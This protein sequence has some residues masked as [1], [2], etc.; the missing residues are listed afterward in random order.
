M[1]YGRPVEFGFFPIP[2]ADD[3]AEVV[4]QVRLGDELGLDLVGIQ[5]HPYQRRHLDTWMLMAALAAQTTRVRIFPDVANL[6]LRHPAVLA[7][8]S[9]SLDIISGGRFELG[10]GAGAL[11]DAIWAMGGPR[12]DPGEAVESLEEAIAVIRALWSGGR[13]V[14]VDGRHYSLRGVHAGPVPAHDIGIWLGAYGPRMLTLTGR[15]A[16]GWIPSSS[17]APPE[18]LARMQARIDDAAAGAGRDPAAVRRLYNLSGVITG[19]EQDGWLQGPV[20]HWVEELTRLTVEQ[21]MDGY[22]FWPSSDPSEQLRRFA[23]E[24][25]PQVRDGVAAARGEQAVTR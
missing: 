18:Q 16:D 10:L 7:K 5:D 23:G 1:D 3:Y 17:Y 13:G 9:A 25:A 15:L 21:G 2:N 20:D 6:P 4:D 24:V 19:G 12:R 11:W 14:R 8:A 22:V